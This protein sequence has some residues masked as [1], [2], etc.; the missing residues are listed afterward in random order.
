MLQSK[1]PPITRYDYQELPEGPP[2]FQVIEGDLIMSPSPRT[3]H[4][5]VAGNIH[6][7]IRQHLNSHPIGHV[8]LAPLDVFLTEINVYQPDLIFVAEERK[9][10]VTEKGIEGAPNLVVEIL[11][12]STARFDKGPKRKIYARTGVQDL[13]LIDPEVKLI[14]V[15]R[16][17][18]DPE[19]PV[20]T[21][22]ATAVFRSPLLPGLEIA[23]RSIFAS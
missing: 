5:V 12:E 19:T 14:Q 13:W 7:I 18:E 9:S 15:Y 11:S 21:Y 22:D 20:A 16:L 4:Q 3:L 23:A 17:A 6:F 1:A 2:Y 10:I 8:F